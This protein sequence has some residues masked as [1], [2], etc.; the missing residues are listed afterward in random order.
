MRHPAGQKPFLLRSH[1]DFL[2]RSA[3][4][5]LLRS[6]D[7]F[8]VINPHNEKMETFISLVIIWLVATWLLASAAAALTNQKNQ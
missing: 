2:L 5:L 8:I 7:H 6:A 1:P 3:D 4:H